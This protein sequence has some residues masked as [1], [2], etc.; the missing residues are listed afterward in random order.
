MA[1]TGATGFVGS[2]LLRTFT[3][4]N[5]QVRALTR[6]NN[7]Q[8]NGVQ[9]VQGD[10][11]NQQALQ[12]L[13]RDTFAVIHC[14]GIVRGKSEQEFN[15]CN[16]QGTANIISAAMKN[17][18]RLPRFLLVSSLAARH[19]EYSWYAKSKYQAEKL[20][21]RQTGS[22]PWTIFRP[23]ALY[24][25]GDREV[26]PMLNAMR[27]GLLTT[28]GR[29]NQQ[30]SLLHIEDFAEAVLAWLT[31][32]N[33]E[34]ATFELDDGFTGGYSWEKLISIGEQ[35]WHRR[36]RRIPVPIVLLKTFARINLGLSHLLCYSPM[37]TPGKINEI[38]HSDWT[39]D[40]TPITQA[41]GWK[42]RLVLQDA[43]YDACHNGT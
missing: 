13:T 8:N 34:Q 15:H 3:S 12:N 1:L 5:W 31:A 42:P 9:W 18:S 41:L 25:P 2:T 32:T 6:R 43:M 4:R 26:K 24:G 23:T 19:P 16:V 40:N 35:V 27:H 28:P 36:I 33:I 17:H 10:L 22:M 21:T 37:L 11:E 39:C 38:T 20:L 14:A 29:L 7:P 30:I